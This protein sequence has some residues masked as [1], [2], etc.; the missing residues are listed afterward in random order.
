MPY[1]T[2]KGEGENEEQ[3][4]ARRFRFFNEKVIGGRKKASPSIFKIL[5]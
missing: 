2:Q 4:K 3:E 1:K 5:G